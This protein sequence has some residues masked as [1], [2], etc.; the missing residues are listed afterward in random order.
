MMIGLWLALLLA[1]E[2]LNS[3]LTALGLIAAA[4]VATTFR[5]GSAGA[6]RPSMAS[7]RAFGQEAEVGSAR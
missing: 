2:T 6:E 4:L 1:P 5:A 3:P 7:A